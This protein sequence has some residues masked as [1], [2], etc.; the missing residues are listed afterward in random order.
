M[1]RKF[2]MMVAS[3]AVA[4]GLVLPAG[5]ASAQNATT[6]YTTKFSTAITYQNIAAAGTPAANVRIQLFADGSGSPINVNLSPLAAGA[7]TSVAIGS[8]SATG[9]SDGFQ[10]GAVMS[11]DQ[12][13]VA[14]MV[15]V[16]VQSAMSTRPLSNGFSPDAGASSVLLATILKNSFNQTSKFSVQNVDSV[17]ADVTINFYDATSTPPGNLVHTAT[18]TNLPAGSVKYFDA[19]TITELGATFNGSAIV[20]SVRTGTTTAGKMVAT[21]LELS[22]AGVTGNAFEG[23][24]TSG[25]KLYMPS[26]QCR[27]FGQE[28]AYAVQNT[29]TTA[30]T[31]IRVTYLGVPENSPAG[32]APTSF[33]ET[34][35]NLAPGAKRSFFGC[36]AMTATFFGSATIESL[37]ASGN[38]NTAAPIVAIAKIVGGGLNSASPGVASGASKLALPYVRFANLARFNTGQQRASIAIQ[39]VG[40]PLNNGDVTVTYYDKNGAVVGTHSLGAIA[41]NAKVNSNPTLATAASPAPSSGATLDDFG[42]YADGTF[43]GSAVIQ[44]PAGSQLVA[45]VRIISPGAG[46][47]YNGIPIP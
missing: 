8:L 15:Q 38:P 17:G 26:A 34:Y 3:A 10:G 27:A 29:S 45:V 13:I 14:T 20:T 41:T 37:D 25:T 21:V 2:G 46:E 31:N 30:T 1:K 40:A 5:M 42:Y 23:I 35:N 16:P 7:G 4:F 39:N 32:T 44:G 22:T 19:G 36:T 47:D 18:V 28:S 11:S 12:P 33:Q 24:T 43:G 9:L 6:A